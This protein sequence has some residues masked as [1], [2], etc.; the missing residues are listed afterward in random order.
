MQLK[1][2]SL[3]H[4]DVEIH[5]NECGDT[6]RFTG[7]YGHPEERNRSVSWDLLCQLNH[8][9]TISWVVMGDFNEVANSFEKEGQRSDR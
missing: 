2:F 4:I 1:S 6:W 7:F 5:E 3:Y 9:Q 8:D